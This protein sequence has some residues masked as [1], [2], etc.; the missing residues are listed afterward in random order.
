M[1]VGTN[2]HW[3]ATFPGHPAAL[4]V[5]SAGLN[6]SSEWLIA[7][8]QVGQRIY[9]ESSVDTE[10]LSD[11]NYPPGSSGTNKPF[12]ALD[13]HNVSNDHMHTAY[14]MSGIHAAALAMNE[15]SRAP[16]YTSGP[17]W[18]IFD[19]AAVD[20]NGWEIRPPY[21]ADP[22][23]GNFFKADTLAE[24]SRMVMQNQYQHM[25]LTHLED[26]VAKYNAAAA[27]GKDEFGKPKLHP[28]AKGPF[29]AAIMPVTHIDSYGG[30]KING[31]AQ[32][33]D[34]EGRVIPGLYAGG[35]SS[36][37]GR[38]HGI[39]RAATHGYMAASS[40]VEEPAG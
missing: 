14:N 12:T 16:D 39:G 11:A 6:V 31:K 40:A 13:W 38:Q 36:G 4:F 28:I 33:V 20:A 26:T 23:D 5:R 3:D 7:V 10:E 30:L 19:Q 35:E 2:S 27:A 15:G 18:A 34:L 22:P 29:Y 21:I 8:N 1:R 25:Q 17:L 32:V 9:N 24:L 37:G